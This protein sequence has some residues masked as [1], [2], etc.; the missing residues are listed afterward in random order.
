M[1]GGTHEGTRK[2]HGNFT[3]AGIGWEEGDT[4][5]RESQPVSFREKD[6][7]SS[8]KGSWR[9]REKDGRIIR[10]GKG[11]SARTR[12]WQ[13]EG[14]GTRRRETNVA[15]ERGRKCGWNG[16]EGRWRC[17]EVYG[18]EGDGARVERLDGIPIRAKSA[19]HYTGSVGIATS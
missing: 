4:R 15:G 2:N 3:E 16:N 13:G 8:S 1:C 11:H 10:E 6:E 18:I 9:V 5:L 17:S 7:R 14:R 12:K 19:G